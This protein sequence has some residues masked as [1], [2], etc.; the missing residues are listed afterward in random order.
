MKNI[1]L[2]LILTTSII[3]LFGQESLQRFLNKNQC[4]FI[5][6]QNS[7][8]EIDFNID[9]NNLIK[10]LGSPDISEENINGWNLKAYQWPDIIIHTLPNNIIIIITIIGKTFSTSDNISIGSPKTDVIKKYNIQEKY[11]KKDVLEYY[12]SDEDETWGLSFTIKDN[13]VTLITLSR[14]D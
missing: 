14:M 13:V 8:I 7:M 6:K 3:N 2:Y 10:T 9:I 12:Y 5:N 11:I 4:K 1:L